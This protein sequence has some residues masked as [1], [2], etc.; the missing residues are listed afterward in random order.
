[1]NAPDRLPPVDERLLQRAVAA[2][3]ASHWASD[4]TIRKTLEEQGAGGA[5]GAV[6]C[7][8]SNAP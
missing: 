6:G 1:M 8:P 7:G 4:P 5:P 2:A 3:E